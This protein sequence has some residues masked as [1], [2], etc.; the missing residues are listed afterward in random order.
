MNATEASRAYK[1]DAEKSTRLDGGRGADSLFGS[2]FV[3]DA[4]VSMR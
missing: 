2:G 3:Y 1:T 4:E